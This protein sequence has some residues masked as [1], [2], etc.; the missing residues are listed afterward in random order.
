MLE[1]VLGIIVSGTTIL[2][3][4]FVGGR[5]IARRNA[6]LWRRRYKDQLHEEFMESVVKSVVRKK[7][8]AE[9]N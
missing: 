1:A 3:V 7:E 4:V 5:R 8:N 9:N 6:L 2:A